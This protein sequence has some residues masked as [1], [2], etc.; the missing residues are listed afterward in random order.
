VQKKPKNR[1]IINN[2]AA[3]CSIL[4][5]FRTDFDYVTL[6]VPKLSRSTGQR[7]RSQRDITYQHQKT[8]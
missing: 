8:L 5:K 1:E 2:S 4:L 6:D 7:S 3:N